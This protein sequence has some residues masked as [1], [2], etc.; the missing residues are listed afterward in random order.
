MTYMPCQTIAETLGNLFTCTEVNGLTRVRTP[1]LYPDGDVIDLFFEV[2]QGRQIMTDFGETMRW[3][4]SQTTSEI[5]SKKQE[6]AIQDILL[7]HDVEQYRGALIVRVGAEETLAGAT[8]RL[9]QAAIAVSNL[10]F[11]SRTRVASSLQDEIAELLRERK[12]RFEANEKLGGRSGRSWRIDFHTWHPQ[13]SSLVQVLS[14]GSRAA[15]NTKANS[16]LAAWYDLSQF[17]VGAQPLRFIS[18]FDDTLD[19]WRTETIRQLEELSDI[20][21]WSEPNRFV[22]MVVSAD[23]D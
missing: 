17:K 5:L 21:Y 3:L 12:I 23:R 1:Y 14:T 20:A 15:A 13:H 18:L 2:S 8:M 16:V 6:Q 4:L 19:V 9:A 7:T 22:E 11:L 10:W